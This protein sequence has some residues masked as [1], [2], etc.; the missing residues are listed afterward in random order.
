MLL[1][2]AGDVYSGGDRYNRLKCQF[3]G[4]AMGLFE[5][6]AVALGEMDLGFGLAAI[7]EDSRE[8]RVNIVCANLFGKDAGQNDGG[9]DTPETQTG[10]ANGL[11]VFPA[12]RIVD[13]GGVKIGVVGVLSPATKNRKMAVE[14]GFVEAMT[15]VIRAPIPVLADV[16]P[17]VREEADLVLLLAH[18]EKSELDSVLAAVDGVDI[19][20]MGHS[21]KPSVTT[22]PVILHG[23]PVYQ[24]S[25][26]GQ[27]LGRALMTLDRAGRIIESTNEITLLD[28]SIPD[29]PE[30]AALVREFETENRS[31][32]K[33]LFAEEQLGDHAGANRPRDVFLGVANCQRCHVDEFEAYIG[34]RHARAYSTLSGLFKH[35]DSGCV[36]CH[37]T[38]YGEPGGFTG[39]RMVGNMVDL[40][41]VQC[42]A[43][44]G[45][46]RDH[47]RDG[48]YAA[49]ARESCVKCH[50]KE[51]DPEFDFA[52]AWGAIEH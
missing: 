22:E 39:S 19:V 38:G 41:D 34:S 43:C 14:N 28:R 46:G 13:T 26:Q 52:T 45:P 23:V 27:Y 30:M 36:I 42:E 35:R 9:E 18:M 11:P 33:K 21:A 8:N 40:I 29:D 51:Q 16:V 6:D 5:Y 47:S 24:A 50:T 12:Y 37:S 31:Y 15:Y 49:V 1:V 17:R 7:V 25:H 2:S 44:H 20:V 48:S 3:I 32:Q 10:A 4:R